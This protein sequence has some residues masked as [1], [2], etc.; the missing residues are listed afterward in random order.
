MKNKIVF[1]GVIVF[2][3]FS[4]GCGFTKTKYICPD[5]TIVTNSEECII[6]EI[7]LEEE[8][9]PKL[10]WFIPDGMRA[11][12]DLFNIY[13]WAEEG[14]LPNI[15][16]MMD[17][18]SYGFAIP[19]Y[20][21][22]TPVNFATLFTGVLPKKH[23]VADGPM[24]IEGKPLNK[25]AIGGFSSAAK[26]VDP[27]W[28]TL[29]KSDKNVFLLSIPGSTP[30]E[31]EKGITVRGRWGGW[32]ADFHATNFENKDS[33]PMQYEQG[34]G[35]RLFFFGPPLTQYVLSKGVKDSW[36][37]APKTF[38]SANE[39]EL[40][41]YGTTI[42]AYIYDSTDNNINNYDRVL[43]SYNK[44]DIIADLSEGE[45]S[46]WEPI[47]LSWNVDDETVLINTTFKIKI[48]KLED[49]GF[50]R[51]RFFYDN[52]NEYLTEPSYVSDDLNDNVGPM[53]DFVDNF[54][55]Q[56]I[57]YPEDKIT[58]LEEMNMSFDWHNSATTYILNNYDV[59][60]FIN[61]IYSPNQMLTSRWWLGYI[62][63][64]SARYNDVNEDE[65]EQLWNEVYGMYKKLDDIIGELLDNADENTY[66][67]V[68]SD[69]GA[70]P[71]DKWVRL[72]NFFAQKGWLEFSINNE[73][74]EPIIDWEKSKVIYLKMD[75]IYINPNGL[76]GDYHRASGEVYEKLRDE[77]INALK[78]LE[79]PDTKIKPATAVVKWEDV[80]EYLDL[81]EDR[82]G[83]LIIANVPGYGWNEE[84][85]NGK[86]IFSTPLKT[87]YKQAILPNDEKCIWAPFI[88]I[89]PN[90]TK[91]YKIKNPIY[92][93]D[94]YTTIMHLLGI[95][96]GT[97]VDGRI[98]TE[99]I[100]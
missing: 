49:N 48:I 69:H 13:K 100:E 53:V 7:L 42:Y 3:F 1:V 72:N 43:F 64:K 58:F 18:G 82:V 27:I 30:P 84:M 23:G 46:D 8:S 90:I 54:P 45:W 25:V 59:D 62:D 19:V 6:Q 44:K 65:R 81:P 40:T 70:C 29:E 36:L 10:Y 4:S 67:V 87:G 77:V 93:Q 31:L 50:F 26:K 95:K 89:G 80:E 41:N 51:I 2:L 20:P 22:H 47:V 96:P 17:Q 15:K 63:P 37:N 14:K 91:N 16:R 94:E 86:E 52:L 92:F 61:D 78:N 32:G 66:V 75:N 38:S 60:M 11:E 68:S 56:L 76:G 39:V 97:D 83:D 34:R 99:I 5:G 98:L 9:N 28:V 21:S 79:D 35:A 55:P 74:G 85:T 71:L 73:T 57:Y 12:P 33:N 24:H 88:I